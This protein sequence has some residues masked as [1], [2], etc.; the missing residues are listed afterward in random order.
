MANMVVRDPFMGIRQMMDRFFEEPVNSFPEFFDEGTLPVDISERDNA[1]IVKASLPG[2]KKDDID[3]QVNQ[4]VLSITARRQ[5]E[6]EDSNERFYRR[7]R[8]YGSVSRR[9]ALPGVVQDSDVEA[10]LKDGVLT[11]TLPVPEQRR[12]KRIEIRGGD[13]SAVIEGQA[14]MAGEQGAPPAP[15][16]S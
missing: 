3:I 2:V 14:S 5:D 4:G 11:L 16:S 6:K 15:S 10:E 12:P 8:R 9:I 7:E 13:E 1:L